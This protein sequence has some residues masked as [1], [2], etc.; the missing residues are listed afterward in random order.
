[1]PLNWDV[2][3]T[4]D[5]PIA[6][7]D[8]P[9][10]MEQAMFQTIASTLIYGKRD[11]V[12]VDAF[13]T[14]KQANELADWVAANGKNLTTIYVTHGHGDHWFGIAT[15][16]ERFPNA[17]A[18]AT[19]DV[20]KVMRQH[21]SPEVLEKVWKASFPGQIP[22]RLL[23]AEELKGNVIDLEGDELVA[24]ELGHTDTDHTTCLN[25]PSIGLVVAGDAAYNDVHLYLAE[26]NAKSRRQWIAALDKIESLNPR[27][28]IASH[29]R[30]GR[31]DSPQIIEETRQYI[32]D[33]DQL[34]ETTTTAQELYDKM[35]ELYPNRVNPGWALWSSTRAVK[36]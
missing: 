32:R 10:G 3:V 18:V 21:A 9:P 28:V 15:L 24:V 12:L 11:A 35:L 5:I 36:K 4:P 14:D 33:F 8:L 26:S 30:P 1:M 20:V 25:V 23:I 7:S 34:V 2:F 16:L 22:E 31:A 19:P 13:M 27:A 6:T 17:R 29:K